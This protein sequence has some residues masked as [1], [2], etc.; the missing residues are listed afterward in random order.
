M[1]HALLYVRVSSQDQA[2]EGFSLESQ[3]K[4]GEKYASRK[5]LKIVKKWSVSESAKVQG[6]KA[7]R[8]LIEYA[9]ATPDIKAI[10]FEKVD[11]MTRNFYDLVEI[12]DLIEKHDK[13]IHFFKQ[14]LIIDKKSKS[15]D[16]LNLD[17]QVVLA[18]NYINNLGEEVKK[19][20]KEK[21]QQGEFP[22]R[23]PLGYKNNKETHLIEIEPNTAPFIRKLF[24]FYATGNYSLAQLVDIMFGEGMKYPSGSKMHKSVIESI[25]KNPIYYGAIRWDG[26]MYQGKHSPIIDK[27]LFETVQDAFKKKSKYTGNRRNFAFT[28]LLTCSECGCSITAEMKK[29]RYVYYHCTGHFGG[30]CRKNYIREE[31][32]EDKLGELL[33]GIE[34]EDKT[35]EWLKEALRQSHKTERGYNDKIITSL[36]AQ[37]EKIKKRLDQA[38]L[39]KLDSKITEEFWKAKSE[40]WSNEI[41]NI[42]VKLNAHETSNIN[43]YE[44]GVRILELAKKAYSLYKSA[45]GEE[46]RK[47]LNLVLSNCYL[48]GKNLRPDYKKPFD[49]IRKGVESK[50]KL[51]RE[52]S[53]L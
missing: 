42:S 44:D 47:L 12:Y 38:Y 17:I 25:L 3:E 43:Y 1:N 41:E 16:K 27:G 39:D 32:L 21:A 37:K 35:H 2:E 10:I 30:T 8:E 45:T 40:E 50:E 34:L 36:N 23:A 6:R 18:R 19:G 20:L 11:R 46:K 7:F 48:E 29:E 4:E 52:D 33:K 22:Q 24:S 9:K 13:E 53:N 5:G 51:P 49:I 26:E 15:S 14:G 28:G 31:Y